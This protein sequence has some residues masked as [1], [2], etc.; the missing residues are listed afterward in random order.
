MQRVWAVLEEKKIPYQYIE[1][2][3][4]HKP[5]SLLSLNPRGLVPTLEHDG[6]PLYES[7][8]ICEFL[9]DVYPNHGL[10]LLPKDPYE[11]AR[12]RIWCDF[13]TSR[14][15]PAFHRLLQCQEGGARLEELKGEYAGHIK[16]WT[17]EM[18]LS[19]PYF[20]GGEPT[21][22]DF[23]YAPWAMRAWVLN[24]FKGGDDVGFGAGDPDQPI[25]NRYHQWW[26]AMTERESIQGT[27]SDREHF[28]PIYKRYAEDRAQSELAKA[29]RAGRGV[30]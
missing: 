22:V 26:R 30:P 21:L 12:M 8:V 7:T 11:K 17:C 13:V 15:I 5:A 1:V 20:M 9:E 23:I 19:G 3:P 18:D 10:A 27:T 16:E 2:N 29:T 6:K 14:L 28:M 24:H 4:Y 25:W